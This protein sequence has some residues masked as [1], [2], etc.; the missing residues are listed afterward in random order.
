MSESFQ[1]D[2][3]RLRED[4]RDLKTA[5]TKPSIITTYSGYGTIQTGYYSEGLWRWRID[6]EDDGNTSAPITVVGT[7]YALRPYQSGSNTQIIEYFS[8]GETVYTQYIISAESTRPIASITQLDEPSGGA[9]VQVLSFNPS[10]MGSAAG[11][12]LLNCMQGFGIAPYPGGSEGA[13]EDMLRNLNAGTLHE[14]IYPPDDVSVPVYIRTG[15]PHEHIGVWHR[16]TF[17]SDGVVI[18]NWVQYYGAQNIYGWGELC[19]GIR[20]VESA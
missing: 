5:Q 11:M 12:C 4:I 18:N 1:K 10:N 13:Y 17:Y 3:E 20:V 7:P 2:M 14:E 9:W 19:D 15:A 16:G 8:D 6:Y